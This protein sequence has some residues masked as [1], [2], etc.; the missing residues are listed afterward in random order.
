V[1]PNFDKTFEL[2]CDASGVGIGAV[3][4]QERK[5][6]AFFSEKLSDAR[7]KWSTYQQ[8]LYA[9]FRALK[10][11]EVYLLPK[12]FLV[13]EGRM[14]SNVPVPSQSSLQKVESPTRQSPT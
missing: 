5:P 3:L 7:K 14:F 10:T 13:S 12:E 6:I 2:E 1:L 4:S 8:E 9:V 11:W